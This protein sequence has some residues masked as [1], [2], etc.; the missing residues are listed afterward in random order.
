M[1]QTTEVV[2]ISNAAGV[3]DAPAGVTRRAFLAGANALVLMALLE[4]CTGKHHHVAASGTPSPSGSASA[5]PAVA[6][7]GA[8]AASVDLIALL[9]QA[10]QASPDYLQTAAAKA[11]ASK[12]AAT[13]A[14]FVRDRISV[15][16]SWTH[17]DNPVSTRRWG[18]RATLR[19]G[20]GTLR[21]RAELLVE[22]LTAAG[23]TATVMAADRPSTIDLPTLYQ[24]RATEFDPD[25]ALLAKAAALLPSATASSS[26]PTATGVDDLMSQADAA[27][28][29]LTAALPANVQ[30]ATIR[31]DLLPAS[32][33]V[34]AVSTSPNSASPTAASASPS[35]QY[36]F[37]LGNLVPTANAPSG[38]SNAPAIYP[39]PN[40]TVTVS[41]LTNP[42]PGSTTPHGEVVTLVTG[43]W[44]AE[45][46]FGR[47]VMLSFV[48]PSGPADLL[49]SAPED[50]PVRVPILRLQSELLAY[51]APPISTPTA[52][53]S[54]APAASPAI[55]SASGTDGVFTGA[56]ITLQG[57]VLAP[58]SSGATATQGV[59][60]PMTTLSASQQKS[61]I[62]SVTT[63][64]ATA[65]ATTF[66]EIQLDVA[67][68]DSSGKSV[69]GIDATAF[70]V[71]D[72]GTP[73]PWLQLMSNS[74]GTGNPRVLV[75]YDTTG[76]VAESWPSPAAKTAFEQSLATTLVAASQQ[77]PFDVQILGLDAAESPD[78]TRWVTPNQADVL[79]ALANAGGNDSVV[80]GAASGT[81]IDQG[82]VAMLMVSDFQSQG[83]QP[84]DIA[85]AQRRIAAAAIPVICLPI[86]KP[87]QAALAT[88]L[89]LSGGTQLDPLASNTSTALAAL[90]QPLVIARTL[91]AYR[92]RYAAPTSG[93][94]SH[95]VVVKLTGRNSPSATTT[96]TAPAA[97]AT[98]WSFAGLYVRV[99]IADVDAQNRHLAG[100]TLAADGSPL[101]ALDDAAAA[102]ETRS[103]I[104]GLTTIAIEPGTIAPA[105]LIDDILSSVQSLEPLLALPKTATAQQ[106]ATAAQKN[107][108]RRVPP[109]LLAL[110]PPTPLATNS[111]AVPTMRVAILQERASA[112]DTL[113][114]GF[115]LP[116]ILNT[117]APVGSDPAASFTAALSMSCQAAAAEGAYFDSSAFASLADQSLTF[118][119]VGDH[120]GIDTFIATLPTA[121]QPAW[122][123]ILFST[124]YP[125]TQ[126][127][128]VPTAGAIAAFW[129]VD[130]ATGA[131]T[132]VLLDGSGG[133]L[134][135]DARCNN[136]SLDGVGVLLNILNGLLLLY[137][138]G[139]IVTGAL[140]CLGAQASAVY[141][142]AGFVLGIAG[143]IYSKDPA[144]ALVSIASVFIP[145]KFASGVRAATAIYADLAAY[146]YGYNSC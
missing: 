82:V 6:S 60:G 56:P 99:S 92:M 18:T 44:P 73:V 143:G 39:T 14:A 23:F 12:D 4:A 66:P 55:A 114:T 83:E 144:G 88:M 101:G 65:T 134:S 32:V 42:A 26:T 8:T 29:A 96:Y 3:G 75:I 37:A 103:A 25:E 9:R 120:A 72:N 43:S 74:A 63:L 146:Y 85:T 68:L 84:N 35:Q 140:F 15:V 16:P 131:A 24:L 78:P 93:P 118:I 145:F 132:A 110:L 71:T 76:S 7:A 61:A 130:A 5:F 112:T 77:A 90:I 67:V 2:A 141:Y 111:A 119:A 69:D 41:G 123:A 27:V 86:G 137:A 10:V 113:D 125:Q 59:Y 94:A 45:E 48:P 100:V 20:A 54:S 47:Q 129:V 1:Q 50:Q 121:Q 124:Y 98:P 97:P 105:A 87:D 81:A 135:E 40:L 62:A 36:L 122:Q 106:L 13:I 34:V 80:W 127:L 38:L 64:Q 33:P 95:T 52:P 49:T 102:K 139:C 136:G 117:F 116:P 91:H 128:L 17:G 28:K 133:A 58:S 21:D 19:G 108:V 30:T 70:S 46:V 109:A 79:S 107:G 142:I 138:V 104:C 31:D 89:M 22:L 11:V 53:A 126:H 51:A 57:D 115:D